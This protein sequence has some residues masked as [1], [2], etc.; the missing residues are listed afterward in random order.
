VSENASG[1]WVILLSL[2]IAAV[3][4]VL[5]LDRS[6]GWWRPEWLL[7][8]L[9]YWTIALP[10]RVGLFT[11]LSV[12]LLADVLEGAAIG[13]NMLSLGVVVTLARLMYQ[14]M[15]VF[16]LTQQSLLVFVLV[17]IHQLLGQWLQ[18]LQGVGAGSFV[19]LVPAISSALIWPLLMPVLRA[20]RRG[21]GVR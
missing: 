7:V 11:A 13:Q 3:L 6:V 5:P 19:F 2:F 12:G 17:G 14:R 8:V 10:Q 1:Y 4:A 21:F 16:T 9:V 15:R 18:S 20:I